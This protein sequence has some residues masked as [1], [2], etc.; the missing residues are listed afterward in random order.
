MRVIAARLG[1]SP[2]TINDYFNG[3]LRQYFPK[4]PKRAYTVLKT[5]TGS[6][7]NSTTDPAHD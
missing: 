5:S 1:R 4:A 2:S 7:G 6:P 3:L